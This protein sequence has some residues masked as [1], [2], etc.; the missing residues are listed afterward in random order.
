M[1]AFPSHVGA[2]KT[3]GAT[4]E[5]PLPFPKLRGLG[6][7]FPQPAA[8]LL[9]IGRLEA[10]LPGDTGDYGGDFRRAQV[11]QSQGVY[12]S[13]LYIPTFFLRHRKGYV[14]SSAV[15]LAVVVRAQPGKVHG[16]NHVALHPCVIARGVWRGVMV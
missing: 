9:R 10:R 2:T 13:P 3:E 4:R 5:W 8:A 11:S 1:V 14:V 15:T 16:H 12:Y 6:I 7:A